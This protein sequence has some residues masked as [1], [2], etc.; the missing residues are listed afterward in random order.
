M[1]CE[2]ER[3]LFEFTEQTNH[4]IYKQLCK[5]TAKLAKSIYTCTFLRYIGCVDM[6]GAI[7]SIILQKNGIPES[8]MI[9]YEDHEEAKRR[10]A[11]L[12]RE[13][14]TT[15]ML[16]KDGSPRHAS[17]VAIAVRMREILSGK[18]HL[19][20][21]EKV[22]IT[23]ILNRAKVRAFMVGTQEGYKTFRV[24]DT[25]SEDVRGYL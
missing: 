12:A 5:I 9:V 1:K 14:E 10:L 21:T 22:D 13:L 19:S 2:H 15:T 7:K 3:I 11:Q 25:I 23:K 4:N 20:T 24:L 17:V 8:G 16:L 6:F 18:V